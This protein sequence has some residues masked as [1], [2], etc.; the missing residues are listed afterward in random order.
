MQCFCLNNLEIIIM[1][2]S[3]LI[4]QVE[5][6][7]IFS[8]TTRLV[9]KVVLPA[10]SPTSNGEVFLFLHIHTN[11]CSFLIL[12]ILIGVRWNLRVIMICISLRT[13]DVEHFFKCFS[14]I[15][16]SSVENCSEHFLIGLLVLWSLTS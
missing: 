15:Q 12:A 1:R 14:T 11:V 3:K 4:F 9:S 13:K 7:P 6:F 5:L 2:K 16:D 8:G 10:F